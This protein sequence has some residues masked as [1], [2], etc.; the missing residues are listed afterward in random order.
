MWGARRDSLDMGSLPDLRDMSPTSAYVSMRQHTPDVSIRQHKSAYT[1]SPKSASVSIRQHTP[2]CAQRDASVLDM[3]ALCDLRDMS[4][5]S[6]SLRGVR[7][8]SSVDRETLDMSHAARDS[9]DMNRLPVMRGM[10]PLW[11]VRQDSP[12]SDLIGIYLYVACYIY[13]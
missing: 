10:S 5:L 7:H 4:P 3:C 1:M 11:G 9:R 8:D 12:L 6:L 13:I 2:G